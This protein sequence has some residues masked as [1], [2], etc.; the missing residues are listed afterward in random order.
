LIAIFLAS[1]VG[2][3]IGSQEVLIRF[4]KDK[5]AY[6]SI[7]A[8][9]FLIFN[10]LI[11]V[12]ASRRLR[13]KGYHFRMNIIDNPLLK[14]FLFRIALLIIGG[15]IVLA[16]YELGGIISYLTLSVL[17]AF[18]VGGVFESYRLLKRSV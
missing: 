8:G 11:E 5:Y 4:V 16:R 9:L 7:L 17:V 12:G 14:L 3:A 18:F 6:A 2:A 13:I 15:W 1:I 10:L